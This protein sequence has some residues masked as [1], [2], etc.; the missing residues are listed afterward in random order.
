MKDLVGDRVLISVRLVRRKQD[1][2]EFPVPRIHADS[3]GDSIGP[4]RDLAVA[5]DLAREGRRQV[6]VERDVEIF[7]G[8]KAGFVSWSALGPLRAS[9]A[10]RVSISARPNRSVTIL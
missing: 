2:G 6:R 8:D 10:R 1:A 5:L 4:R 9:S 3:G 7:R